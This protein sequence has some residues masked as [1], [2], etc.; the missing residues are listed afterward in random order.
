MEPMNSLDR[1][2]DGDVAEDEPNQDLPVA[3]RPS[4]TRSGLEDRYRRHADELIEAVTC[5]PG[6]LAPDTRRWIVGRAAGGPGPGEA[7]LPEAAISLVDRVATDAGQVSDA[8]V[9]GL[10]ARGLGEEATFEL[11]VAAAVGAGFG[12]LKRAIALMATRV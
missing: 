12:R 6:H 9:L 2:A 10:R 5:R 4:G 3:T 8:D 11:I 7:P 1:F